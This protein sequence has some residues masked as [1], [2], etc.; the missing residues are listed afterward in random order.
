MNEEVEYRVQIEKG[1]PLPEPRFN[2]LVGLPWD[3]MDAGDSFLVTDV[4][5]SR[6][7]CEAGSASRILRKSF[8]TRAVDGGC[9]VWRVK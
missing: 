5:A 8:K 6:M 4:Y 3:A 1:V 9:R 2:S 7:S